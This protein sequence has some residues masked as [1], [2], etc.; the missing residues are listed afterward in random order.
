M[1]LGCRMI[2]N[3]RVSLWS[4]G[5]TTC[6]HKMSLK[7]SNS[8]LELLFNHLPNV[9]GTTEQQRHFS[10]GQKEVK[11]VTLGYGAEVYTQT[12]KHTHA[13]ITSRSNPLS[14]HHTDSL[15]NS[16]AFR[17]RVKRYT[18]RK[19]AIKYKCLEY[20]SQ[21]STFNVWIFFRK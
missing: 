2:Q 11:V 3:I 15:S 21:H 17:S 4:D 12:P 7:Q 5:Q 16:I 20:G 1:A 18:Y 8:V 14:M 6:V 10:A 9:Q 19:T 13:C